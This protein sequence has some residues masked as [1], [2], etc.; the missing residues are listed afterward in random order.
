[1]NAFTPLQ[2]RLYR[3]DTITV[4]LLCFA[5]CDSTSDDIAVYLTKCGKVKYLSLNAFKTR[6]KPFVQSN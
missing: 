3:D 6:F 5:K 4:Q 2:F 1:M